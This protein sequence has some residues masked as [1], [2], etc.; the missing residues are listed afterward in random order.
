MNLLEY[1]FY[2]FIIIAGFLLFSGL[3]IAPFVPSFSKDLER[4]NKL[5]KLKFGDKFLEIGSGTAK[6][7][8]YI[9]KNNPNNEIFAIELALPLFLYGYIKNK[10]FGYK[11]LKIKFGNALKLDF[12]EF[13]VI[14]VFGQEH[15]VNNLLKP[16]I[17]QEL[18]NNAKFISYVF[19]MDKWDYKY[20]LDKKNDEGLP[21]HIYSKN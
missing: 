1:I 5:T 6:V 14:Y 9:A 19:K 21:I 3:S 13:D 10:L 7:S 17:L 11:N 8:S 16:K 15:T 2:F 4:I 12:S 20:V 18:K